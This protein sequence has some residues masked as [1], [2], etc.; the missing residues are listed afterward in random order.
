MMDG[1]ILLLGA[2]ILL[3]TLL[4]GFLD[5]GTL[6]STVVSTRAIHPLPAVIILGVSQ[7][8]GL[9]L[10]GNAVAKAL[11]QNLVTFPSPASGGQGPLVLL[12]ALATAIGWNFAM[13]RMRF[14][15]SSSHVLIGALTGTFVSAYGPSAVNWHTFARM[16]I[17]F[18][19]VPLLGVLAS[20]IGTKLFYWCGEYA[21]PAFGRIL[22]KGQVVTLTGLGLIHGSNDG[23]KAMGLVLLAQLSLGSSGTAQGGLSIWTLFICGFALALG[24]VIGSAGTFRTLGRGIYRVQPLQSSVAQITSF[25]L[26]GTSSYAGYPMSTTQVVSSSILG[27]GV[28]IQPRGIRWSLVSDIT[29]TWCITIPSAAVVA[30]GFWQ[31][32]AKIFHVVP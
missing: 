23:Q 5:G 18:A 24:S 19:A 14:P 32:F 20:Y 1:A 25:F 28:A 22:Q 16:V 21:T 27:A 11:A 30:G 6:V 15:N 31:V 8:A 13:W 12:V 10:F 2:F 29:K 26:V 9:Y 3:F 7:M 4:N 17:L